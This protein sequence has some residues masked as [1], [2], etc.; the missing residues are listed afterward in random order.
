MSTKIFVNLPVKDLA[1][2]MA[3][4]TAW[5]LL[6]PAIHGRNGG[7]H[8]G[9]ARTSAPCCSRRRSSKNLRPRRSA[10]RSN[11]RKRSSPCRSK[12]ASM[13][14]AWSPGRRR[15]QNVICRAKDYG[16]MYQHGFQDP[17]GHIWEVFHM[18]PGAIRQ[19]QEATQA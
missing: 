16:F 10:M 9:F 3:F 2:S 13:S 19:A 18:E 17:N 8:G 7:L 15:G 5:I 6:Q 11:P 1:K 4:F 14:K 12:A